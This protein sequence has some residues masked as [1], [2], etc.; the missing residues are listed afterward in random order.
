MEDAQLDIV[1]RVRCNKQRSTAT[2]VASTVR[3]T[4][5]DLVTGI[6]RIFKV[7]IYNSSTAK[8]SRLPQRTYEWLDNNY[9][10]WESAD[11]GVPICYV[12][13][14]NLDEFILYP[15]AD[16]DHVGTNYI[17]IYN[18]AK[19]TAISSDAASPDLPAVLHTA[20]IDYVVATGLES[21]GYQDIANVNWQMYHSKLKSYWSEITWEEDQEVQMHAER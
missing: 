17:E 11:A 15:K 6:L 9:P 2:S 12:Y 10:Q 13:D 4:L 18:S 7:R 8:W 20:V 21:R 1:W 14:V 5:T 19:P 16:S 3:Y